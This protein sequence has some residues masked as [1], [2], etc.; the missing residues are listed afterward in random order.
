MLAD[1]LR[2]AAR[3]MRCELESRRLIVELAPS[4]IPEIAAQGGCIRVVAERNPRWYRRLCADYPKRR[5]R[6]RR[7]RKPDTMIRRGLT[8][9]AL[10]E[11][12]EGRCETVYAQRLLPYVIDEARRWRRLEERARRSLATSDRYSNDAVPAPVIL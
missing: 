11:I 2:E 10:R 1:H 3:V 12:E 5:T 4:R 6:P 8:L 9:R 7:R